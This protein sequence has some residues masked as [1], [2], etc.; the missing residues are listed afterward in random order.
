M[1][2]VQDLNRA[3]DEAK[4]NG[5]IVEPNLSTVTSQYGGDGDARHLLSAKIF[6]KLI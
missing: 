6:R 4:R 1:K 3:M 2:L 5:L